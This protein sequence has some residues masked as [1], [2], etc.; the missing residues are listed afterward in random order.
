MCLSVNV[1]FLPVFISV[2]PSAYLHTCLP[3]CVCLSVVDLCV[4]LYVCLPT[5]L[6]ACMSICLPLCLL[7]VYVVSI[8]YLML[9][10]ILSW[11]FNQQ[12]SLIPNLLLKVSPTTDL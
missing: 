6:S 1:Y 9:F 11:R 8:K 7:S 12:G 10:F 4:Y 3:V 5:C 2:C